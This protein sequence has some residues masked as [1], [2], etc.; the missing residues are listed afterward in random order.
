M[1]ALLFA[2]QRF[3]KGTIELMRLFLEEPKE[4]NYQDGQG[5]E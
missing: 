1:L 2:D 5:T 4:K 3:A